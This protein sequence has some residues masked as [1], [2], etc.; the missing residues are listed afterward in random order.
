MK[1]Q[2]EKL[3][4][5]ILRHM[6]AV[7]TGSQIGGILL[8]GSPGIGKTTFIDILGSLLGL[9]VVTIEV[10]HI[11]E[12][13]IINIPFVVFNPVA[14]STQSMQVDAGLDDYD[15]ILAKSN[16]FQQIS[17]GQSLTDDQYIA[18][19]K[20]ASK[21][22]QELY[23]KL[24]GTETS[25]PQEIQD[26]RKNHTVI[27][28]LDEYYRH[29]TNRVR[30]IL[31]GILNK[32]IGMHTIPKS[33]YV[34]YASNMKDAGIEQI[35]MNAQF[36]GVEFKSPSK[37]DWFSWLE[38]EYENHNK[39][40]TLDKRLM[41]K[42]KKA[43][44]DEDINFHDVAAD[45]YTSPRRWEQLL[46][47]INS[48]LPVKDM[49]EASAL[50][51]NVKNKFVR[52]TEEGQNR[53]S[54]L[55]EKVLNA[56][57]DLIQE[58]SKIKVSK[59]HALPGHQWRSALDHM[60]TQQIKLG[61]T[62]KFVPVISGP[63]GIGKTY[64]AYQVARKHNLR[65]IYIDV[66]ELNPEDAI[67]MPIPG[68]MTTESVIFETTPNVRTNMTV[69]FSLPSLY[70]RI[71][72]DINEK[73]KAYIASLK[74]EYGADA[75]KYIKAYENQK[76][77][78]LI[79]FDEINATDERTMNAL[80]RV[81]LEKNFGPKG[82]GSGELLRLPKGSIVI[83]A[84][85][86]HAAERTSELTRHFSDVIDTIP[87]NANWSKTKDYL[88]SQIPFRGVSDVTKGVS[89]DIMEE[90]IK[91]FKSK[92]T[93][94][95]DRETAPFHL[96]IGGT[97]VYISPREYQDMFSTLTRELNSGIK[98][99]L[100][101][102]N[103]I[104]D[105]RGEIDEVVAD[106]LEDS[107]NFIFYKHEAEK[108]EF[109]HNLRLWV[110]KI[111]DE[112][113]SGVIS[114]KVTGVT[115]LS[116]VLSKYFDGKD[117][118]SMPEDFDIINANNAISHDEFIDEIKQA[119]VEKLSTKAACQKY[120]LVRKFD[121]V[122]LK[123]EKLILDKDRKTSFFEN[124]AMA[125]FY[126]LDIHDFTYDRLSKLGTAINIAISQ[127]VNKLATELTE[128]EYDAIIDTTLRIDLLKFKKDEK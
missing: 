61:S 123:N 2:T 99:V 49:D 40:V 86:P 36:T 97:E 107:L 94:K 22:V 1:S 55:H 23:K 28:F 81:I 79:F 30:N 90:F 62:G 19:L 26:I 114:K 75:D 13:H 52:Q 9:K 120:L 60:V 38:A 124:F 63:P 6:E 82:D 54:S 5:K 110:T 117:V 112:V 116:I 115:D 100:R 21:V 24:G 46:L 126:T 118:L 103:K 58:T 41:E 31:R 121:K 43:L 95:Y 74:K 108:E 10:P 80:R 29:T 87:A 70:Y 98:D 57:I 76:Y 93:E 15:L 47:Y 11:T 106:A 34:I 51:T 59:E 8:M 104:E 102:E 35:H 42:F 119:V 4:K 122:D 77:K 84:M 25:I 14:N 73:D 67:G 89:M 17:T 7:S 39:G 128:D 96:E 44:K 27:L 65:L 32:K 71:E 105:I 109:M 125:L 78:Y 68:K 111:P 113:F 127:V 69:K 16:L 45:V 66:S 33:T 101:E 18:H 88:M 37:Q 83:G 12:E 48:S 50:I 56:V 20:K 92:N 64:E 3:A 53:Y 72:K 91:K 85:N